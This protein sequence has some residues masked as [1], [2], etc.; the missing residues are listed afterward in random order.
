MSS[1][2]GLSPHDLVLDALRVFGIGPF[3]AHSTS[4]RYEGDLV[5]TYLVL[6]PTLH[7]DP[8]IGFDVHSV[9]RESLARGELAAPP[10]HI[11]TTQ[12]IEHALRH[13]AWLAGDDPPIRALL[14]PT[15]IEALSVYRPEPFRSIQE[16][17]STQFAVLPSERDG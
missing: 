3:V 1:R 9:Q 14:G 13:L 5:L 7:G 6:L 8:P 11:G 4:W 2:A 15:W 17:F 16:T 12:V 10:S